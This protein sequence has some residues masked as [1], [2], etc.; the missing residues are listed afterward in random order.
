MHTHSKCSHK[1]KYCE[2]CDTVY[3]EKCS[4]EWKKEVSNWTYTQPGTST[5]PNQIMCGGTG[6][7]NCTHK[8]I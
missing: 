4:R 3:C 7:V 6:L 2:Q 8:I 1:L 5:W